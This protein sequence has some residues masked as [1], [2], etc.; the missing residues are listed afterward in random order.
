MILRCGGSDDKC[1]P[2]YWKCDGSADCQDGT[3][4]PASCPPRVCSPGITISCFIVFLE[5]LIFFQN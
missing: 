2:W 4:E 5:D 3:D 1:I